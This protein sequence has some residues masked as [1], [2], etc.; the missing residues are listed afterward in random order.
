MSDDLRPICLII[1]ALGGEGGGVLA[2]WITEAATAEG[3]PVQRTSV[4]GVAQRTGA[5]TYYIEILPTKWQDLAGREPVLALFPNPGTLDLVV[6]T[7]ILE[8]GRAMERGFVTPDRTTLI[9]STHRIFAIAEKSVPS[10]GRYDSDRIVEAAKELARQPIL[11]DIAALT[12]HH[13]VSLNAALLGMIAASGVLPFA[14][15]VYRVAVRRAGKAVDEN[16]RGFDIGLDA[17]REPPSD[18]PAA[19]KRASTG[20]SPL[21]PRALEELPP[22]LHAIAAEA[23]P[24]LTRF[25]SRTYAERWLTRLTDLVDAEKS[26]NID[27]G[28][29]TVEAAKQLAVWMSFEDIIRVA[30]VK[31]RGARRDLVMNEIGAK[32]GQVIRVTEFLKPGIPEWA[33]MLPPGM[34]TRLR[35]WADRRGKTM[36][37]GLH[38]RSDTVLGFLMLYLLARL[39]WWR[40]RTLRF[41][42]ENADI[43][44]W[45]GALKTAMGHDAN[46]ARE[47]A[48]LPRLRKGYGETRN[49]GVSKYTRVMTNVVTPWLSNPLTSDAVAKLKA[50]RQ[51][52]LS[53]ADD[54]KFD[55]LLDESSGA[56]SSPIEAAAE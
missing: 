55:K 13:G 52:A 26:A 29:V 8:A 47:I 9:A 21:M 54:S 37:V 45:L 30:E 3:Y 15:T 44:T 38:I 19:E 27:V 41:A 42:E 39:R 12:R 32:P 25:Q 34:G 51:Q 4:P 10:D 22:G 43:D 24:R 49:R 28:H 18:D 17:V 14:E 1:G 23:L 5:T 6:A 35:T 16:L 31:S 50:L 53:D 11:F 56:N 7:E 2:D 20:S 46:L 40:P 33:D 48:E 36:N